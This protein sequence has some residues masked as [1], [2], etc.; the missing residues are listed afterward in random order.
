MMAGTSAS[1]AAGDIGESKYL[2]ESAEG[3]HAKDDTLQLPHDWARQ[4]RPVRDR[5]LARAGGEV[6]F[7][8]QSAHGDRGTLRA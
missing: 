2:R 4:L 5:A 8:P 6:C 7:R 3:F 1:G